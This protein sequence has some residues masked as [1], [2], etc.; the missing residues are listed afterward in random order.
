MIILELLVNTDEVKEK[1]EKSYYLELTAKHFGVI[2][3]GF[4][5]IACPWTPL[6]QP[7]LCWLPSPR[8]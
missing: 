1:G 5:F 6:D 7:A 8:V 4:N 3:V 2:S